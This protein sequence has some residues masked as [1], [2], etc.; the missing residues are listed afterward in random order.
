MKYCKNIYNICRENIEKL[1]NSYLF[2]LAYFEFRGLE[3]TIFGSE[4]SSG[5]EILRRI[6]LKQPQMPETR[7]KIDFDR[8][9][10]LYRVGIP[11]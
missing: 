3:P 1:I 9:F 11:I 7:L 10:D 4:T 8:F 5:H 2:L 6:D